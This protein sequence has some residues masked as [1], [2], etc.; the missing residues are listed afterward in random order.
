MKA[1]APHR[2]KRLEQSAARRVNGLADIWQTI[3]AV[4]KSPRWA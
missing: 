2:G 1:P 4:K 3:V